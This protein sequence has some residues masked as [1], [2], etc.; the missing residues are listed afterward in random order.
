M[1]EFKMETNPNFTPVVIA[2]G[3]KNR[4]VINLVSFND[5]PYKLDIRDWYLDSSG[6]YKMGKGITLSLTEAKG[7]IAPKIIKAATEAITK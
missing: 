3:K 2:E 7:I 4:K 1:A 6:G 5:G